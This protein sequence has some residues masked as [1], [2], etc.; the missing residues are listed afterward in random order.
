MLSGWTTR[1]RGS[2]ATTASSYPP[3]VPEGHLAVCVGSRKRR[4]VVR[5]S[6]LNHPAFRKLLIEAE[7]EYGYS[8]PGPLS[9]PCEETL[10]LHILYQISS[11]YASLFPEAGGERSWKAEKYQILMAEKEMWFVA[12][13]SNSARGRRSERLAVA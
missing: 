10:F 2:L 13:D 8:H 7:E 6:H 9:L 5:A 1:A 4:F 11:S 12:G 3:D